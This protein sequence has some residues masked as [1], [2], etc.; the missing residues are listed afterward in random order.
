[1]TAI[2]RPSHAPRQ[3]GTLLCLFAWV[4][5]AMPV[6]AQEALRFEEGIAR[7]PVSQVE[8][9]REQHWIRSESGQ[10]RERLVLYR[11]PDGTAFARKRLDYRASGIAP[12]FRFEDRRSGYV[13]GLRQGGVPEVFVRM[14]TDAPMQSNALAA[15]GLVADA[16]FDEFIRSR[17]STLVAGDTVP[18]AFAVPARLE[19]LGFSL[20]KV[21]QARVDD[22]A[23]WIFRLRLGGWLGWLAPHIDV[24]YGQQSRRLLRFEGL[25]NLRDDSGENPLLARIDFATPARPASEGQWQATL[26]TPLSACRTGR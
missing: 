4:S 12:Q 11:C 15:T 22:E 9:Y 1:M 3:I 26:T 14:T 20:R 8:L 5:A 6:P 13:E 25:S 10:P 7:D 21:G 19:S 18:F 2:R 16:G 17:W 24:Y 23:A